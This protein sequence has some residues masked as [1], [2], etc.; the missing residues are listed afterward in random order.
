M[1]EPVFKMPAIVSREEWGA[2]PPK[3]AD[4][5]H[6]P[7]RIVLHHSWSPDSRGWKGRSTLKGIQN[8][9]MD[10]Q[11]WSDIAYHFVIAPDGTTYAGVDP[12]VRG[13]HCG[14]TP[15]AGASRVFGNTGSI[16]VCLIGNFDSETVPVPAWNA[17]I[18]LLD[19][20]KAKYR[21]PD[22]DV[23]GHFEAWTVPPKTCPGK[24]LAHAMGWE[25]R[26]LKAYHGRG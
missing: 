11:A 3:H 6:T 4:P 25:K 5:A 13:T 23:F 10:K 2:R 21:I 8:Y 22:A 14:G 19:G 18:S 1:S 26:W 20:L 15:P 9:H 16:G 17:L 24:V 7:K 12:L